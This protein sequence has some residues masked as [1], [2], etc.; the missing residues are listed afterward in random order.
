MIEEMLNL[1]LKLM[2]KMGT[3]TNHA[4]QW[5]EERKTEEK[6]TEEK[7]TEENKKNLANCKDKIE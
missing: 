2:L 6:K 5:L 1:M 7:K 3:R 4:F